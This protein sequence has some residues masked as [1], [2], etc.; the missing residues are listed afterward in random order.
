[1]KAELTVTGMTCQGCVNAVKRAIKRL[2]PDA[3]VAVD[4]GSGKVTVEGAPSRAALTQ[5]V[6][7]AGF[8]VA[9]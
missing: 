4:L 2:D 6:E 1:M 3:E 8:G 7:A 9:G 5:A